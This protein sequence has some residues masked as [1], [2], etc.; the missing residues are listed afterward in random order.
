MLEMHVDEILRNTTDRISEIIAILDQGIAFS[1]APNRRILFEELFRGLESF[2]KYAQR[3][4]FR[5]S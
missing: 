2:L 3:R 1:G 4:Y 5:R